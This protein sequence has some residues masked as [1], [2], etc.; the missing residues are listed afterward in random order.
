[1]GDAAC[2]GLAASGQ[3]QPSYRTVLVA[4]QQLRGGRAATKSNRKQPEAI[5]GDRKR[6]EAIGSDRKPFEAIRS[7]RKPSEGRDVRG[8]I[9]QITHLGELE[10]E[11]AE[12]LG[13]ANVQVDADSRGG[14]R[15]RRWQAQ[16]REAGARE[17]ER[18]GEM[19]GDV[20]WGYVRICGEISVEIW[21]DHLAGTAAWRRRSESLHRVARPRPPPARGRR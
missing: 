4:E 7:H 1:M 6:S 3:P 15:E 21:G 20:G 19:W 2:L 14:E 13:G 16:Q 10:R 12:E 5:G 9:S 18:L 11:V 17:M 8:S